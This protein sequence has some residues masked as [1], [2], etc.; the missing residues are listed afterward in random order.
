MDTKGKYVSALPGAV[1]VL[2]FSGGLVRAQSWTPVTNVFPGGAAD[3]ALLLTDGTVLVHQTCGANWY[4]L[5]PSNTGS[6]IAGT[7]SSG[8]AMQSTHNPLY[9]A[10]AV[11]ADGRVVAIGGEYNGGGCPNTDTNL[12]DIYSPATNT[13]SVL[14]PPPFAN[15]GD[16]QSVVLP[17]GKFLVGHL[18]STAIA[19]LDPGTL[20][21]TTPSVT[22]KAD[23]NSEEGWTLLPNTNKFLTVDANPNNGTHTE[24]YDPTAGS[25]AATGSTTVGISN[26]GGM[27]I[28]PEVGPA[29]LRPDG[30]IYQAG[31]TTHNDVYTVS[32][33]T[34]AAGIPDFPSGEVADGPA[35]LLPSGNVLVGTSGFFVAPTHFY[36]F[37]TTNAFSPL[38]PLQPARPPTRRMCTVFCCFRPGRC[39]PPMARRMLRYTRPRAQ[40][41]DRLPGG[42]PSQPA[43][44]P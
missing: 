25:W 5:T 17:N 30:T 37:M 21:W 34:W 31:A 15:V 9:F 26:N 42:R 35:A 41:P 13:W 39:S 3:T 8:G 2:L 40:R 20:T 38:L 11:L 4:K 23:N 32:T 7:W 44:R 10:S 36:E 1:A 28:V 27:A 6:Y 24:I 33:G 18:F 16:G 43:P 14:T 12:A 29:I 22:G 19:Q